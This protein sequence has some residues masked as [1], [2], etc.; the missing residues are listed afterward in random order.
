MYV[1]HSFNGRFVCNRA[2][3]TRTTVVG[4]GKGQR[5]AFL[6]VCNRENGLT[7]RTT[8]WLHPETLRLFLLSAANFKGEESGFARIDLAK[9]YIVHAE[10]LPKSTLLRFSAYAGRSAVVI[11]ERVPR[12]FLL[13]A[14]KK[15]AGLLKREAA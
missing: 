8:I 12:S 3:G 1:G 7:Q 13:G 6:E 4:L 10:P 5:H 11:E 2:H 14:A 9:N 15:L